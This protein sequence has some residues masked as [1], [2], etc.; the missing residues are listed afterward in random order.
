MG[1]D[2]RIKCSV[3]AGKCV[4]STWTSGVKMVFARWVDDLFGFSADDNKAFNDLLKALGKAYP[5]KIM[6]DMQLVLG[7]EV[8]YGQGWCLLRQQSNIKHMM[9]EYMVNDLVN[10]DPTVPIR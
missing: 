8:E 6:G 5:L 1:Y 4:Y 3:K 7:M 2:P 10:W 9:E